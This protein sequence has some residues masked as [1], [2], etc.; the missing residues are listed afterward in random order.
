[1]RKH[2]F[3]LIFSLSIIA[4]SCDKAGNDPINPDKPTDT[5][6]SPT[7][8]QGR[9]VIMGTSGTHTQYLGA[10]YDVMGN[11]LDNRSVKSPVLDLNKMPEDEISN[12]NLFGSYG[13]SYEGSNAEEFLRSIMKKGDFT[14]PFEN[15]KDLLFTGTFTDN[16]LF[17]KSPYDYSTQY[18]FVAAHGKYEETRS[19]F[20]PMKP[21]RM[22][23]Y[24]TDEFKEDLEYVTPRSL[25]DIYGTH[26]L[27]Q[28]YLGYGIR[29]LYC[30]IV[31]IDKKQAVVYADEGMTAR[32][33]TIYKQENVQ[34]GFDK[35][36]AE[37]NY[38]G[39]I[40][41]EF[42]GGD[43]YALPY[44]PLTPNTVIGDPMNITA[45]NKSKNPSNWTL[46]TLKGEGLLPIYELIADPVK[47]QQVKDAVSAYIKEKQLKVLQTAPI[48]QAWN[49]K[50]HRYF[51]SFEDLKEIAGKEYTCEGVIGTVFSK[52]QQNTIPLYLFSDGKND[53]LSTSEKPEMNNKEMSYKGVFGYVY[54]EY[55]SN[56]THIL[57]EISNGQ[58]YAY[59]SEAKESYGEK[60]TWK[61]TGKEFYT[62]K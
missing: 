12:L 18:T 20:V 24:L 37:K 2:F 45:W 14:M 15:N 11:F 36:K 42:A 3:F 41:V 30:P 5:Y 22:M 49:E 53:R 29:Q 48:I 26:V 31:T 51:T 32:A 40:L 8:P 34:I 57:Y 28:V 33:N 19:Q 9:V 35:E 38:G 46:V 43:F 17:F 44:L 10:G 6:L 60:N 52:P 27:T 23:R 7:I 13:E 1:M 58:D 62:G 47:K 55:S 59:T 16:E 4:V 50:H 39:A 61:L 56:N 25:I 54:K 21:V